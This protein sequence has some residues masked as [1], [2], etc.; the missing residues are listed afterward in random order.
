MQ[1]NVY[2]YNECDRCSKKEDRASIF[3][4]LRFVP[5][6]Q[7][8]I[9]AYVNDTFDNKYLNGYDFLSVLRTNEILPTFNRNVFAIPIQQN[10]HRFPACAIYIFEKLPLIEYEGINDSSI[11]DIRDGD[12]DS[13]L[14]AL[15]CKADFPVV[16]TII[17]RYA[18][19]FICEESFRKT[20]YEY[21]IDAPKEY[22]EKIKELKIIPV[23]SKEGNSTDYISWIG[24]RIF[25][26]TNTLCSEDNYYVLN[27]KQLP[28]SCCERIFDT[29]INEMSIEWE[30]NLYN[31]KL[32]KKIC[33]DDDISIYNYLIREYHC[34]RLHK[35]DSFDML[36]ANRIPLKNQLDNITRDSL[37]VC[38]RSGY[39]TTKM[40]MGITVHDECRGLAKD[41]SIKLLSNIHYEDIQYNEELTEDDIEALIDEPDNY[42][43][44][45]EEILR[46]FYRDGLISDDLLQKY[47][48]DYISYG[49]YDAKN[50]S[51]DFP[52]E[53]VGNRNKL[54]SHIRKL[55]SKPLRIITVPEWREVQKIE[56]DD[57]KRYSYDLSYSRKTTLNK[58]SPE[59]GNNLCFC[60][61]CR[62]PKIKE[63][64]EVNNIESLPEYFFAQL[65][66]ALCLEC[67]KKFEAFRRNNTIR[68]EFLKRITE[69][70][71]YDDES[72]IDIPIGKEDTITFTAKHLAEIQEIL[73]QKPKNHK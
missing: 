38:D 53:P 3:N 60:Q 47:D 46:G 6:L 33:S 15:E 40:I 19:Q 70:I 7:G 45:Y 8:N 10:A 69:Y 52:S 62:M 57:G 72:I 2:S 16:F 51:F 34:G 42:F 1:R 44:N 67:S 27:E 18:E 39:F 66:I 17:S 36:S 35:N 29:N 55:W 48:L 58:Y 14:N 13:A 23:Y 41:V 26:K 65:R 25:V 5:R 22:R 11:I 43:V 73:K 54:A 21:L 12:Y 49:S 37:F 4:F 71:I 64:I 68:K 63:Y 31:S 24:D 20:L 32:K 56:T 28:K 30:H 9:R 59:G 50:C 61:M